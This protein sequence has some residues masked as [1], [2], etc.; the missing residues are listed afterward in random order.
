LDLAE[1]VIVGRV[2][3]ATIGRKGDEE[4]IAE[5]TQVRG[6]GRW[7]AQ[8]FLIFALGR[9]DVFPADDLGVRAAIRNLHGLT[10]LPDKTICADVAAMWR[11]YSS[12]ASWYCW[13]SIDLRT[14]I[15]A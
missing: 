2:R 1:A 10:D 12:V 15:S 13:R 14:K 7:T 3:L 6:I 9:L 5:L 8:M 11:P 4:I